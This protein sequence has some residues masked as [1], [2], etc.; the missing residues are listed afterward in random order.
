MKKLDRILA[1][2]LCVLT[3]VSLLAGCKKS[4]P[5][6]ARRS[7]NEIVVGLAQDLEG[8]LDP[9]VSTSAAA[10]EL[11]FNVFEGLVKPTPDGEL[12]P[13]VAESWTVSDDQLTYTFK[14]RSGV[15]FHDGRSVSMKDAYYSVKRCKDEGYVTALEQIDEMSATMDELTIKLKAPN[16]EFLSYLTLAVIP[17]NYTEQSSKPIG[18][19]PFK[20]VSR[21]A[22]K[23]LV[24]ERF[25]QYWGEKAGL[26]KITYSVYENASA[27]VLALKGG[28]VDVYSHLTAAQ[29]KEL[30]DSFQILEGTMNLV[31]AVYLN[32]A[33]E[34]LSNVKVRQALC[35]A[36]D[37]EQVF[38]RTADGRGSAVG[39]S[40]YPAF[41]KYFMPELNDLYPHDVAEAKRL[42]AEA[43]YPD[44]FDLTI[45]VPSNHQPH[46][47]TAQV[48]AEQFREIGVNVTIDPIEWG[49]WLNDVYQGRDFQAT[50]VGVDASTMTARA[51]LER[52]TSTAHNNFCNYANADY[53]AAFA[54]ALAA[55]SDSEQTAA[56]KDAE[57]ILAETAANVYIQD[58][59]DLVAVRA[60]LE[61]YQFYP[62]YVM[63]MSTL[64]YAA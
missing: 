50:V 33:Y 44:G 36:L 47:D 26:S 46:V 11:L 41:R 57:R 10:R 31:Q 21:E 25:D 51:M 39:S 32:N 27:L 6:A 52:F 56:Y 12:V 20:F 29:A 59:A 64:H 22:Q 58:L 45:R 5:A 14:L 8:D 42:L 54:R 37:R 28:A 35:Y 7:N 9:H 40:M 4:D 2:T 61:G 13:A 18:T 49:K 1:L 38:N 43:G 16:N 3:L 24:L 34:P 19:G 23:N 48:V 63:D 30:D 15:Y 62:I 60:G 17:E 53:D 55:T